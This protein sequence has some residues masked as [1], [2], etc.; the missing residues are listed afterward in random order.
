MQSSLD[1]LQSS[2]HAIHAALLAEAQ[3]QRDGIELFP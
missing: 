3:R 2:D 1:L